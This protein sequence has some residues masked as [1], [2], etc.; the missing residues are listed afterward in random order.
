MTKL[1]STRPWSPGDPDAEYEALLE[2]QA[3]REGMSVEAFT[4][5]GREVYGGLF[6]AARTRAEHL[7]LTVEALYERDRAFIEQS[8]YPSEACLRP[9]EVEFYVADALPAERRA[10]VQA[11]P[12][13]TA[14]VEGATPSAARQAEWA[15]AVR[16]LVTARAPAD[17]AAG[18][19]RLAWISDVFATGVPIGGGTVV[20]GTVIGSQ[21]IV[22]AG[23]V[24]TVAAF[25]SFLWAYRSRVF[26]AVPFQYVWDK[27]RGAA[28]TA[29][30]AVA[31]VVTVVASWQQSEMATVTAAG[32]R[33]LVEQHTTSVATTAAGVWRSTGVHPVVRE[34][35]GLLTVS[36]DLQTGDRAVYEVS[37]AGDSQR[38]VADLRGDTGTIYRN[39]IASGTVQARIITGHV[40]ERSPDKVTIEDEKGQSYSLVAAVEVPA[41]GPD[42]RVIAVTN[43]DMTRLMSVAVL[44]TDGKDASPKIPAAK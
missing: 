44:E 21:S 32:D 24:T 9:F 13:C 14:L 3:A 34:A 2:D 29:A 38:F 11:C 15:E 12:A 30:T 8:S 22:V 19:G 35:S 36:T 10:H 26:S 20:L 18:D 4:A 33:Q 6:E 42:E 23:V 7:G 40:R 39:T 25:A 27:S 28:L 31:V 17:T 5:R 1:S 16:D 41:V 37:G 43:P